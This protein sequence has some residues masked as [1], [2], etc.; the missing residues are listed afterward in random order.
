VM[1]ACTRDS[2]RV[3][4]APAERLNRPPAL[5]VFVHAHCD[6]E[7]A[8]PVGR[9]EPTIRRTAGHEIADV[10][11]SK[12]SRLTSTARPTNA[13][14]RHKLTRARHVPTQS[15][16][17]LRCLRIAS[18]RRRSRNAFSVKASAESVRGM[19]VRPRSG[20]SAELP[21]TLPSSCAAAAECARAGFRW[22]H[23]E[24][25]RKQRENSLA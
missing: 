12:A 19:R 25:L 24:G 18:R 11:T 2:H 21:A 16:A 1:R 6:N 7:N 14:T 17:D 20:D 3:A 5:S 9:I 4:D 13:A 8:I 10:R 23:V 15:V 22:S